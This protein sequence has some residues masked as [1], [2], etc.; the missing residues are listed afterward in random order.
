MANVGERNFLGEWQ[1]R[2]WRSGERRERGI[3]WSYDGRT[4]KQ[5]SKGAASIEERRAP[6][7][8]SRAASASAAPR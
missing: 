7:G 2:R 6:K 5:S 4:E 8:S 1:W 3:R